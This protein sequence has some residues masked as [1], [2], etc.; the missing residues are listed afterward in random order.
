MPYY[1]DISQY[2]KQ[3]DAQ[4]QADRNQS[5][6]L[7][8][9]LSDAIAQAQQQ[10]GQQAITAA[11]Q[12]QK[13]NLQKQTHW[14]DT[15]AQGASLGSAAGPWGALVGG[16][17][18]TVAGQINAY[19]AREKL[20]LNHQ[21]LL[22]TLGEMQVDYTPKEGVF[23]SITHGDALKNA[24]PALGMAASKIQASGKDAADTA[25]ASTFANQ[26]GKNSDG[27]S[28]GQYNPATNGQTPNQAFTPSNNPLS[29]VDSQNAT[30]SMQGFTP[31]TADQFS[32]DWVNSSGVQ[33]GFRPI[34]GQSGQS[35]LKLRGK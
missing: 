18:G 20:G 6:K 31:L 16:A 12:A 3:Y 5:D 27:S 10:R 22:Q 34:A 8:Q 24:V 2:D 33:P 28:Y 23:G 35:A 21:P 14:M 32:Q 11:E 13:E 19:N 25:Q 17:I 15:A 7:S 29:Y 4:R 9:T 26:L 1:Q 30:Q